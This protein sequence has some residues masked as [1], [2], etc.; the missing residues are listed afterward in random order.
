MN[1]PLE[2]L[3]KYGTDGSKIGENIKIK[4]FEGRW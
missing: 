4:V 1:Y 2:K 3:N